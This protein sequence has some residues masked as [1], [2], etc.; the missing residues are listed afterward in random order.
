VNRSPR[1]GER[2]SCSDCHESSFLYHDPFMYRHYDGTGYWDRWYG[3]Y[4]DPWWYDDYWYY[5]SWDGEGPRLMTGERTRWGDS[6]ARATPPER[7]ATT[8]V[9]GSP[10]STQPKPEGSG[11]SGS[12]SSQTV[13]PKDKRTRW[14]GEAAKPEPP[15][16]GKPEKTDDGK[17][18][19]EKKPDEK[20]QSDDDKKK[21]Q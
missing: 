1:A 14:G 12:G 20:K 9:G 15:K 11:A 8:E 19:D 21:D 17:K 4:Y 10:S 7:G 3:Y 6:A 13:E 16:Q 2:R 18:A 5:D